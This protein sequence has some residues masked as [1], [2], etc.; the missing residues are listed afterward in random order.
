ML[1]VIFSSVAY[2]LSAAEETGRAFF[3]IW[4]C[5]VFFCNAGIYGIMPSAIGRVYGNKYMGI[6]YGLVYSSQVRAEGKVH[7]FRARFSVSLCLCLSV[8]VCLSLSL[9]VSLSVCLCLSVC[10]S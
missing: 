2:T 9:C 7:G 4:I 5:L 10:L 6:N 8:S 3:L 1:Y